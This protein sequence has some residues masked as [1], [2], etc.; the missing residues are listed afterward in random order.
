MFGKYSDTFYWWNF[1]SPERQVWSPYCIS[2][3]A[4]TQYSLLPPD[5]LAGR[6]RKI[7]LAKT[8]FY[9]SDDF[10]FFCRTGEERNFIPP[11]TQHSW[12]TIFWPDVKIIKGWQWKMSNISIWKKHKHFFILKKLNSDSISL[13]HVSREIYKSFW[14]SNTLQNI[15]NIERIF[16]SFC[17]NQ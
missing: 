1:L 7:I 10:F 2:N 11:P 4:I 9:T 15:F 12:Q 3:E 6:R 13:N 14:I 5:W 8:S 17:Q 16:W